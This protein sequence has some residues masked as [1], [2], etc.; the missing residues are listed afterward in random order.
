M[1]DGF[2]LRRRS[3][4]KATD[5]GRLRQRALLGLLSTVGQSVCSGCFSP[6]IP[7]MQPVKLGVTMNAYRL[8][9]VLPQSFSLN[10]FTP[11]DHTEVLHAGITDQERP[12][13]LLEM[14]GASCIRRAYGCWLSSRR[15][16]PRGILRCPLGGANSDIRAGLECLGRRSNAGRKRSF[17]ERTTPKDADDYLAAVPSILQSSEQYSLA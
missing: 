2:D 10:P 14:I 9:F 12:N 8:V 6:R 4:Q 13:S 17:E 3:G 15:P 16:R 1:D 5:R 11:Q 7:G